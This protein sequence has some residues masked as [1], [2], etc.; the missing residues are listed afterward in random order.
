MEIPDLVRD[1]WQQYKRM[2]SEEAWR[3]YLAAISAS[4]D[5]AEAQVIVA[6]LE[7]KLAGTV[8]LYLKMP[9]SAKEGW[10]RD[11]AGMRLL[12]VHPEYRG[13]GIGRALV[14]ECISRCRENGPP[15]IALHTSKEMIVARRIYESAGFRR[16]PVYDFKP[17][18]DLLI[19]AYRLDL[20]NA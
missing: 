7:G 16:M 13:H 1:A 14:N 18:P 12:A 19:L 8:T 2:L 11:W 17:L 9:A 20:V 3:F 10:P 15:A 4:P 5:P 6:H